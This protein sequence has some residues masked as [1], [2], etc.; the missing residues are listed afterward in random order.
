MKKFLSYALVA[1]MLLAVVAVSA[2][3]LTWGAGEGLWVH[4]GANY[5]DSKATALSPVKLTNNADGSVTV[6]QGGYWKDPYINGGVF[7]TEQV[8]IDGLSVEVYFERAPIATNDCWFAIHLLNKPQL[9]TTDA[10]TL[11]YKNL[12]RFR[13]PKMEYYK[14]SWGGLGT[15]EAGINDNVFDIQSGDTIIMNAKYELGQYM[16]SYVH[17]TATGEKTF[18]VP[19]DKT[20]DISNEVFN[21]TGKGY[22]SVCGSLLGP[23]S[24]WKYT[25]KVT[26]GVGLTAEQL[27]NQAFEQGKA[28]VVAEINK[29]ATTIESYK[30]ES[31]G[32]LEGKNYADDENINKALADI[33]EAIEE[34]AGVVEAIK[35]AAT[36]E[37]VDAVSATAKEISKKAS[38][39][40]N[41]VESNYE[42]LTDA[43]AEG[44]DDA[45]V[46]GAGVP[47]DDAAEGSDDAAATDVVDDADNGDEGEKDNTLLIIIVVAA[48][49]VVIAVVAVVLSKKKKK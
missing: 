10:N 8:G 2:S 37:E 14:S 30:V 13:D 21:G 46:E 19:A 6:E 11:G 4:E 40:R 49:V 5:S 34:I 31:L 7:T 39:A 17:K 16:I 44:S 47:S 43:S 24:D 45:A 23:D 36:Q 20:K 9:F 48:V 42:Y 32:Y 41:V 33:D 35:A 22:V 27:A 28:T 18:E 1:M 26:E 12:I 15:S 29:Y 38:D 25:I 3:A